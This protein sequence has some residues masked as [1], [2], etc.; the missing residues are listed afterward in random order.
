[1]FG[2]M[3]K[4]VSAEMLMGVPELYRTGQGAGVSDTLRLIISYMFLDGLVALTV[5]LCCCFR[6]TRFQ[7]S[8]FPYSMP[9]IRVWCASLFHTW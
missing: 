2:I 5:F 4:D 7:R 9:S 1:M 3:D 6:N 8:G